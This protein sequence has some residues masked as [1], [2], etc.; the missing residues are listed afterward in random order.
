MR[1]QP[2]CDVQISRGHGSRILDSLRSRGKANN[3][4]LSFDGKMAYS[5]ALAGLVQQ[6]S[7][8]GIRVK[9]LIDSFLG[10]SI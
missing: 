3:H 1:E 5:T 9:G 8:C 10:S 7:T 4:V 6:E 2:D